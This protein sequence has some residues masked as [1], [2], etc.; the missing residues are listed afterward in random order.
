V[1]G[2]RADVRFD[3]WRV[4]HRALRGRYRIAALL[5]LAGA[6]AG[7]LAG[8]LLGQR[9][10]SSTGLV[11][12]AFST[13][14]SGRD[15]EPPH[16]MPMLDGLLQAQKDVMSSREVLEA[17]ARDE[18]W[19]RVAGGRHTAT[20]QW[21][22]SGLKVETR[23][24]SD[25]LRVTFTDHSP[26]L[27]SAAVRSVI[28]AYQQAFIREQERSEK[29]RVEQAE[30]RRNALADQLRLL[31]EELPESIRGRT[32]ADAELLYTAAS[33]RVRKLRGALTDVQCAMA[34]GPDLAQNMPARSP[35]EI[36]DDELL[37]SYVEA[38]AAAEQQLMDARSRG[39]TPSHPTVVRLEAL[40]RECRER[41]AQQ[42]A[43][44]EARRA[45]RGTAISPVPLAEREEKLRALT[46]SAE[47]E[48]ETLAAQRAQIASVD[49]RAAK[50]RD[51]LAEADARRE[52]LK[53]EGAQNRL[54]VVTGGEAPLTAL[55]DQRAKT[56]SLGGAAGLAAAVGLQIVYG[57]RR[58]KYRFCDD[59]A[60]DMLPRIP[61][62]A[63][64]PELDGD[65]ET[66]ATAVHCVHD[67]RVRLQ[68]TPGSAAPIYLLTGAGAQSG[69]TGLSVSLAL[70]FSAAG[71]RTLL[72]DGDLTSRALTELL[73]GGDAAGLREAASG[74]E[75]LMQRVRAGFTV[76]TAGRCRPHDAFRFSSAAAGRVLAGVRERFDVVLVD[77]DPIVSGLTASVIAPHADGALLTLAREQEE[78]LVQAALARLEAVGSRIHGAVYNRALASDV[79]ASLKERHGTP[80]ASSRTIPA[81]LARFGPLVTAMLSSL[82]LSREDELDLVP[83]LSAAAREESRP[84]AESRS[85]A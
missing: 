61:F 16:P 76:L 72:V 60:S 64:L 42:T 54:T 51:G 55:V 2:A 32:G 65:E 27:A 53:S 57:T 50:I 82:A 12:L 37:R 56:A 58:R 4:A 59:V 79:R 85:A 34:G 13:P 5:A 77:G 35:G 83:L 11:R 15:G 80:D 26:A 40:L 19:T 8:T 23:P 45:A 43:E 10:F 62:V 71:Y 24:K 46:L 25:H 68:P 84:S 52:S 63:V 73:G 9:L 39:C 30:S 48:L 44:S 41:M 31:E 6:A 28:A 29:E 78:S 81:R 33:E 66:S 70:S 18:L 75:P 67:L 14:Q 38:S 47:Q 3:F 1:Y 69:T 36:A 21:L 22:A 7:T 17:A 74:E 20:P 49:A